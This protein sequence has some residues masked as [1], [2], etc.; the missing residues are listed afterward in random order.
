MP[1]L[2][3]VHQLLDAHD[4]PPYPLACA[5][6]ALVER[7][8]AAELERLRELL[9]DRTDEVHRLRRLIGDAII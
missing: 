8:Q 4:G 2:D 1:L 6:V 3:E 9:S 5:I 7:R